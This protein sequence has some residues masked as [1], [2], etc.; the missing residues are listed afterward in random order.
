MNPLAG[1]EGLALFGAMITPAVLISACGLLVLSTS[2]RL[3]RVSRA[4]AASAAALNGAADA[5]TAKG[6]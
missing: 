5:A 3:A 4:A 6:S 1:G 2:A